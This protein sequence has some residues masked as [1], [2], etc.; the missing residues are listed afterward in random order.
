[1][2]Q[3]KMSC[4]YKNA[5]KHGKICSNDREKV[6]TNS[7]ESKTSGKL[8]S[9]DASVLR[10]YLINFLLTSA[11]NFHPCKSYLVIHYMNIR[12]E[13]EHFHSV[14]LFVYLVKNKTEATI[15]ILIITSVFLVNSTLKFQL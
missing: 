9:F 8:T 5:K 2:Y 10:C 6:E 7:I 15:L 13:S 14:K 3:E 11:P 1:M 4:H 12:W